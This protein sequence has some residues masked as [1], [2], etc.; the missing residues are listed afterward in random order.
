MTVFW[1]VAS[2]S[3]VETDRRE[4]LKSDFAYTEVLNSYI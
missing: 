2:S 3:L 4:N 1:D